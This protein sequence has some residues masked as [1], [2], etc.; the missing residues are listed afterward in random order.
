MQFYRPEYWSGEPFPSPGCLR[1]PGIE[2]RSPT[3]Q[4]DSLPAEPQGKPNDTGVGRLSLLWQIF[5]TQESNQSL[6]HYRR[7]LYRLI[8]QGSPHLVVPIT[9][10]KIKSFNICYLLRHFLIFF[11]SLLVIMFHGFVILYFSF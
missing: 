8:Y 9:V 1:N 3:L 2:P 7:I 6:L 11:L 10:L 5:P 4:A